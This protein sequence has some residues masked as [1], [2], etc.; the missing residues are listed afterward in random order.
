MASTRTCSAV[1]WSI[2]GG[3]LRSITPLTT[4]KYV[5]ANGS[6]PAKTGRRGKVGLNAATKVRLR[7]GVFK[8][9]F[10]GCGLHIWLIGQLRVPRTCEQRVLARRLFKGFRLETQQPRRSV[11]P[12]TGSAAL[13]RNAS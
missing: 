12:R 3:S 4:W 6:L 5:G 10:L 8:S 11:D 1:N 7:S 2:S 9:R 13:Q